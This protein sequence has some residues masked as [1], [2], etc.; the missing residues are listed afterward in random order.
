[1]LIFPVAYIAAPV[2]ALLSMNS[3][4]VMLML[5][6]VFIAPPFSAF[7]FVNLMFSI[8]ML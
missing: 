1:M 3:Q 7:A 4:F 8:F 6:C 2:I 5:L